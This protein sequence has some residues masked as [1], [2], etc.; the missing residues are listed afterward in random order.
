[1]D[2]SQKVLQILTNIGLNGSVSHFDKSQK[3]ALLSK[4]CMTLG[5]NE[6]TQPFRIYTNSM[7]EEYIYATKECCAQL[8]HREC[9]SI[10]E[11]DIPIIL[12]NTISVRVKGSN[13]HDRT[14]WEIGS[15]GVDATLTPAQ[16][17]HAIMTAV[18]KAKRRLTLC[19]SGLGVLADVELED[20]VQVIDKGHGDLPDSA[21]SQ[22]LKAASEIAKLFPQ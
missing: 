9:I 4:L 13:K 2:N 18:T 20:M 14:S 21:L 17:A 16:E 19:L 15:V 6:E 3:Q 5:L 22:E 7:G 10:E 8:R 11:I 1:M 12:G